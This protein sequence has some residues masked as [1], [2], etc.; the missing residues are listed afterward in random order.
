MFYLLLLAVISSNL[1]GLSVS[2]TVLD[3]DTNEPLGN[4]NISIIGTDS[5]T[6]TNNLGEFKLDDIEND[7]QEISFS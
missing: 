2:G 1:L 6:T 4:V 7:I 5:G 3:S